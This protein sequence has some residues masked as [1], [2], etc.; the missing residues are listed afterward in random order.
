VLEALRVATSTFGDPANQR[1]V[2][3]QV[4]ILRPLVAS[5]VDR[6]TFGTIDK[7]IPWSSAITGDHQRVQARGQAPTSRN[8][9]ERRR[10]VPESRKNTEVTFLQRFRHLVSDQLRHTGGQQHLR[11][12]DVKA[13]ATPLVTAV[14]IYRCSSGTAVRLTFKARRRATSAGSLAAT[15]WSFP[16]PNPAH[17]CKVFPVVRIPFLHGNTVDP[18]CLSSRR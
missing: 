9:F 13:S 2:P 8:V 3:R 14:G 10:K 15:P 16:V 5:E 7:V 6:S 1:Q 18:P 17:R 12:R 11:R 4:H